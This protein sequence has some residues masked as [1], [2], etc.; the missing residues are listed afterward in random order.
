MG[1]RVFGV[2]IEDKE[3]GLQENTKGVFVKEWLLLLLVKLRS[4]FLS[5]FC[6]PPL[7]KEQNGISK[8]EGGFILFLLLI[9]CNN[10]Y[11]SNQK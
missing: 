10:T 3:R 11:T 2:Q 5:G 8:L 9:R 1:L 6:F 7:P 4:G